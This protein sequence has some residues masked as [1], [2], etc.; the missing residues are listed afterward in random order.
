MILL[1]GRLMKVF[2]QHQMNKGLQYISGE[3]VL[4]NKIV[5]IL[6]RKH[7]NTLWW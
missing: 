6:G 7:T 3:N 1:S 5:S 2:L 4:W